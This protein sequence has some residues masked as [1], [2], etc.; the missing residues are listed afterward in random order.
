[1]TSNQCNPWLALSSVDTLHAF[2]FMNKID[3]HEMNGKVQGQIDQS[4]MHKPALK[5]SVP[6]MI[7]HSKLIH[8]RAGS[9]ILVLEPED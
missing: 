8:Y 5:S 7:Q 2:P 6:K 4:C 3:K 1:M 9:S